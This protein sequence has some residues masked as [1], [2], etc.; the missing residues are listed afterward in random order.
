MILM[1]SSIIFQVQSTCILILMYWGVSV[2]RRRDLHPKIMVSA[3]LWDLILVGQIELTRNAV[4]KASRMTENTALLNIH[5]GMA[6]S[7]VLLYFALLYTGRSLL[8]NNSKLK[9]VHLFLGLT[10]L[11]LRTLVYI[12]SFMIKS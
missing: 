6:I 4:A 8:K 5:V 11:V 2:R 7:C 1:D 9:K 10:T 3:I 12:T